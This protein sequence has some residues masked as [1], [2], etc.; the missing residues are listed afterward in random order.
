MK[1]LELAPGNAISIINADVEVDFA[2]PV[3]YVEPQRPAPKSV[4]AAYSVEA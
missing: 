2:P 3:G 1:V 4:T